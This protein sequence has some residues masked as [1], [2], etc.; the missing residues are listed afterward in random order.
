MPD[1]I[2]GI[3]GSSW[4]ITEFPFFTFLF[5]DLHAHMMVIPLTLLC[6]ALGLALLVGMRTGRPV[7]MVACAGALAIGLGSLWTTNSWDYPSYVILML[8]IVGLACLFA[9]GTPRRKF[10]TYLLV[11]GGVVVVSIAA[12]LP[13]HQYYETFNNG[14]DASRWRTPVERFLA[15]HSLFI[16]IIGTFLVVRTRRDLWLLL[17]SPW[18]SEELP[19]NTG[20]LQLTVVTA[21]IAGLA[22]AVLG[23]W[24]AVLTVGLLLLVAVAGWRLLITPR[25]S[26]PYD[27][28]VLVM[29]AMA[30]VIVIGVDF[31][32]V[33]GDIGRMNTLFKYYLEVWVFLAIA[34]AYML[35]RLAESGM[36]EL[37]LPS[38]DARVAWVAVLVILVGSS[39]VYTVMGTRARAADRFVELPPTMDGT[40]YMTAAVHWEKEEAF[41][42]VW[43]REAIRWLQD[44]VTGSPVIL[45]AH[46]EQYRWGG[47]MANYTGLPTILGWPWHQTQQRFDYHHQVEARADDVHRAYRT[48][49]IGT[50]VKVIQE[51][52]VSYVVAGD[53][54]RLNY[55]EPGL[56]KF[57]RMEELGLLTRVYWNQGTSIFRVEFP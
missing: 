4:H 2:P 27:A 50:A 19:P 18:T 41:P 26:G 53:L 42:L 49:D 30:G 15:I 17:R 9:K 48:T 7:W 20:W 43:D 36:Q 35:W 6:L 45:E 29:V 38:V 34:A 25:P 52:D 21:L 51:Y 16:F 56:E 46:M 28:L 55:G 3:A 33:E 8:G 23:Y 13:F 39:L 31:V 40:A 22:F 57:E 10:L 14:L 44:N 1:Y 5:A 54:E 32:T 24:T 47:R 37:R 12:F 11:A